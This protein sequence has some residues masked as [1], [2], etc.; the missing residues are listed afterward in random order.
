[1]DDLQQLKA[2]EH[3]FQVEGKVLG[4]DVKGDFTCHYPSIMDEIKISMK[5]SQILEGADMSTLPGV[6]VDQAYNMAS[7]DV[8]L[9]DYPDWFNLET[10]DNIE[11]LNKVVE[12]MANFASDFRGQDEEN[13]P[14][15][16]SNEGEP[17]ELVQDM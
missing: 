6:V 1:M 2:R 10:L 13:Q 4:Q 17:K 14:E 16:A 12:E 3:T 11:V 15:E 9:T 5:A 8:L 7:C